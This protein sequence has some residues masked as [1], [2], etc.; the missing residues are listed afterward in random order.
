MVFDSEEDVKTL[1]SIGVNV[2]VLF[3][4]MVSLILAAVVIG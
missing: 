2:L 3:G 4:V 1:K